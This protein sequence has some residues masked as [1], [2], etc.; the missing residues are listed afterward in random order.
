[1]ESLD[2][3]VSGHRVR[4]P[5]AARDSAFS[6]LLLALAS[7]AAAVPCSLA[8]RPARSQAGTFDPSRRHSHWQWQAPIPLAQA[9]A[10]RAGEVGLQNFG[11]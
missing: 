10:R 8:R 4:L 1:M 6:D 3:P 2:G 9:R 11:L 5:A 7:N